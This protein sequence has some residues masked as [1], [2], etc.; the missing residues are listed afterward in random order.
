[1]SMKMAVVQL[2]LFLIAGNSNVGGPESI[3]VILLNLKVDFDADR[4][5]PP[6]ARVLER[7]NS[8]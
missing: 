6:I 2:A 4:K 7:T 8:Y 5:T 1:M 3:E